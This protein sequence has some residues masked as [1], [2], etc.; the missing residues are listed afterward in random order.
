[1]STADAQMRIDVWLVGMD[2]AGLKEEIVTLCNVSYMRC[3]G[4]A[5][6]GAGMA[7]RL[8]CCMA[9]PARW[10]LLLLLLALLMLC[11][12]LS[13]PLRLMRSQLCDCPS[14]VVVAAVPSA[15]LLPPWW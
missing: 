14:C 8:P 7:V 1:M 6:S 9:A 10:L 13:Y 15:A 12:C 5:S 11:D 3:C 4:A 2:C